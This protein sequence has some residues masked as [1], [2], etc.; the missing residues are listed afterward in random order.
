VKHDG[1]R[2][3]TQNFH[4]ENLKGIEYLGAFIIKICVMT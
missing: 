1:S 2:N 4:L 3:Y